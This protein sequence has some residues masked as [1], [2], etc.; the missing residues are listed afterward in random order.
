MPSRRADPRSLLRNLQELDYRS[1]RFSRRREEC[2]QKHRL[3]V[4]RRGTFNGFHEFAAVQDGI[5]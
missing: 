5:C 4:I 2:A 1:I 3:T